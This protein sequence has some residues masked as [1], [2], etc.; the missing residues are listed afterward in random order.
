MLIFDNIIFATFI[1]QILMFLGF[2]SCIIAPFFSALSSHSENVL[3]NE[4]YALEYAINVP[5]ENSSVH[6]YDSHDFQP[7]TIPPTDSK[8]DVAPEFSACKYPNIHFG[9]RSAEV[10]F[11]YLSRPPPFYKLK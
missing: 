5:Q 6:F 10:N 7:Q 3:P 1:P 8:N 4:S 11:A 9:F 2:A